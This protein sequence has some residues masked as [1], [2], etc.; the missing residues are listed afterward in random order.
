M[1]VLGG[2]EIGDE[3][4]SCGYRLLVEEQKAP[5]ARVPGSG[6][7]VCP[8]CGWTM[9]ASYHGTDDHTPRPGLPL[10]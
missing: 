1:P 2:H 7:W 9:I 10:T 4:P 3:C 8:H 5:V 6:E